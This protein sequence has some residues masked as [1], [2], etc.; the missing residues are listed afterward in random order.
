MRISDWSADVCSSDL[1]DRIAVEGFDKTQIGEVAVEPGGGALS[2]FLNRMN[3]KF[4]CDSARFANSFADAL[5]QHQ[6][7]AVARRQ[8]RPGL[9]DADDRLARAQLVEAEPEIQIAFEIQRRHVDILVIREPGA[10]AQ[11]RKSTRLNSSH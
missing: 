10:A 4:Q 7:M 3:R 5:G 9:R 2:R 6:M 8:I 11:D 1:V